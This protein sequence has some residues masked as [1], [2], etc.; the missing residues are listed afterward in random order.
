MATSVFVSGATG[1]I[2]QHIVKLL[3]SK[4][5]NVVGS[6]R[7]AEKGDHLKKI[8]ASD[9]FSYEIVPD[10]EPAGA[11]DEALKR[12]PEVTVFLHTASPFHFKA[13]NVEEELLK[14]AVNG[15]KNA[16]GAIKA[17]GPQIG[18]VVVTS[19]FAAVATAELLADPTYTSSEDT[20]NDISWEDAKKSPQMGYRGS[21]KFAEKA[22]WDF[23][24]TENPAFT[25]NYVNPLFVFGPQAFASEIK[26]ELNTSSEFINAFL[27]MNG[28]GEI[29][30]FKGGFVDVRDVAKAH[31]VAFEK[32]LSNQRLLLNYDRVTG[33]D[34]A[35]VLNENFPFLR[36]KIPVG[37]PGEGKKIAAGMC[38]IDNEKTKKILGFPLID[39]KKSVVDSVEQILQTKA[40]SAGEDLS[41]SL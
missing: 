5:Y 36:G 34:I 19:S 38:K 7:S 37:N 6:V 32:D 1:F 22:A 14:P 8:F 18:K 39:L 35:D 27:K 23:M 13:T 4:S 33:Q 9:A 30:S 26:N 28:D 24:A 17:F 40:S 15:T 12:H 41:S 21:K 10:V 20:W 2:A 3:L 11:F 29:P 31:L 16:L 25:I